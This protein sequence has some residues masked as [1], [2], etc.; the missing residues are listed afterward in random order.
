MLNVLPKGIIINNIVE[1]LKK[2]PEN[3][4]IKLLETAY[5]SAKTEH[6]KRMAHQVATYYQTNQM[7]NMQIKNL[8]H[9][10]SKRTLSVFIEQIYD[11]ISKPPIKINFL[12]MIT[13]AE[14]DALKH[15]QNLIFP[16][17]DLKN[18]NEA[19]QSV[20]ARLKSE[21]YI[22]FTSISVTEKNFEI[23]T[24]REV[25]ILL[26]KHG[27]RAIF[28]RTPATNTVLEEKL[29]ETINHTRKSRPILA[30]FIKKDAPTSSTSLNYSISE[31][32]KGVDYQL[33]L[34][35]R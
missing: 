27:V 13:V 7:A 31:N 5:K 2:D 32:I 8:V 30:F 35:L 29:N 19:N 11:A 15:K 34:N 33:R 25:I 22:F 17:I 9:N 12:K 10:T 4:V 6:E 16:V 23:V 21:G 20:L 26:I 3:G 1:T 14:A 24:S 18:L 28:Y